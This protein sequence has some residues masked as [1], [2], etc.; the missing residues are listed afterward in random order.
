MRIWSI[1]AAIFAPVCIVVA[2]RLVAPPA[3][4][5][6]RLDFFAQALARGVGRLPFLA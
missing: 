1:I 4:R 5:P 2:I 3:E 6:R